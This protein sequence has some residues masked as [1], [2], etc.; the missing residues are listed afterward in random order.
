[1]NNS[2]DVQSALALKDEA[3]RYLKEGATLIAMHEDLAGEA[4]LINEMSFMVAG[5]NDFDASDFE[6]LTKDS[7]ELFNCVI[8]YVKFLKHKTN[9]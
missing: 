8:D 6:G 1:M 3:A 7:S 2:N 4:E 5:F 9:K